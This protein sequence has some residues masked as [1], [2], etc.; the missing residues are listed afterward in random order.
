MPFLR[1]TPAAVKLFALLGDWASSALQRAL[2]FQQTRDRNIED[3]LTG[4]YNYAYMI[5]RLDQEMT[6]ARSYQLVLTVLALRIVDYD[7][8]IPVRVPGVLK[9]LSLVL[10]HHIRPID[11]LGK[12]VTDDVFLIVLPHLSAQE[13]HSLAAQIGREV[14]A[15]GFK[16]FD[17]DRSLVVATGAASVTADTSNAEALVEDALGARQEP[18][19]ADHPRR[20]LRE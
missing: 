1:F 20:A 18:T 17:D 13:G 12:Y 2:R 15:F 10:R 14:E 16:P 5:K 8:I 19:R 6:R 4:A 7:E 3:E 9:T 11:I